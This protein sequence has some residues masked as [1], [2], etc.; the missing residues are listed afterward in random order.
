M[1]GETAS[2]GRRTP[3]PAPSAAPADASRPDGLEPR[4]WDWG[5]LYSRLGPGLVR[6]ASQRFG[7]SRDD[8]EEALQMAATAIVL[9]AASVRSPEAYLTTVFLRECLGLLRRRGRIE[10]NEVTAPARFD[11]ADDSCDRIQVVCRFRRAFA[12]L[13]ADCRSMMRSCLLD[14]KSRVGASTASSVPERT[15]YF[16]Y[17]KCLRMLANALG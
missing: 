17:R 7:L 2:L 10:Q 8:A 4:D 16:R 11:P 1:P 12:L 6:L 3:E 13:S 14:G 9:S 15:I 5:D